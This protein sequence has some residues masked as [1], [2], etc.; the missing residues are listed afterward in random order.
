MAKC[1]RCDFVKAGISV[2]SCMESLM[3]MVPF[4]HAQTNRYLENIISLQEP[5]E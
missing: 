1:D 3:A 2:A 4:A 5:I